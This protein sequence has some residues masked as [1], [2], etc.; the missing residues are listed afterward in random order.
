MALI[1]TFV[2]FLTAIPKIAFVLLLLA[3]LTFNFATLTVSA[4]YTAASAALT[5]M[6]VATVAAREAGE[7]LA[8]R[9]SLERSEKAAA[10]QL[11]KQ[12]AVRKIGLDTAE[13]A[14]RRVQR[15]AARNISSAAGEAIPF[16]GVAVVA[17]AL[18]FEIQDACDTA[19]D[20]AGFEAA[21]MAETDPD[22]A[23]QAAAE[24]FDCVEMIR[25]EI[26]TYEDLPA[27]DDIWDIVKSS[28]GYAWE[29]AKATGMD[30]VEYDWPGTSARLW[31]RF[32]GTV[33]T[34]IDWL[35]GEEESS[36]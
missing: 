22:L 10:R 30:L 13:R 14:Q 15:G 3:S 27:K 6:G 9:Q 24:S 26:P 34:G 21:L 18:A 25:E 8:L 11:S 36:P 23:H 20:M 4:V 35:F 32:M 29:Q 12:K 17:G 28:P 2:R 19:K 33:E 16:L 5:G 31:E 7:K 1:T